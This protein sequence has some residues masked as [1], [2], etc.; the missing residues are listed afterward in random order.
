MATSDGEPVV[1]VWPDADAYAAIGGAVSDS[2]TE[3]YT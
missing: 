3:D 2:D 1:G